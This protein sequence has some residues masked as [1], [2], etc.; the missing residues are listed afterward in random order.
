MASASRHCSSVIVWGWLT[1]DV[2]LVR[3]FEG[4]ADGLDTGELVGHAVLAGRAGSLFQQPQTAVR[5]RLVRQK[6][7]GVSCVQ[8]DAL[9]RRAR[10]AVG[11]CHVDV[12]EG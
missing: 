7:V 1:G 8:P 2:L 11:E 12:A 6:D 4:A 5:S 9:H 3:A 10:G